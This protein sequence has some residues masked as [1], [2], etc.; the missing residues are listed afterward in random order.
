MKMYFAIADRYPS[1]YQQ[2][3]SHT[4]YTGIQSRQKAKV[5]GGLYSET[6]HQHHHKKNY[7][8]HPGGKPA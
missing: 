4:I 6:T 8:R 3:G 2:D 5:I 7:S 1:R